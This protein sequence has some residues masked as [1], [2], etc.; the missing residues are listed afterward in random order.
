M[1][2]RSPIS[3][4]F[5]KVKYFLDIFPKKFPQ[6]VQTSDPGVSPGDGSYLQV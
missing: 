2:L 6:I 3:V 1:L 5:E 4:N